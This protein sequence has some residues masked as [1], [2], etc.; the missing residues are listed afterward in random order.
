MSKAARDKT[1][2]TKHPERVKA[3]NKLWR[4]A[5]REHWVAQQKEARLRTRRAILALFGGKCAVCEIADPIVLDLDHIGGGGGADRRAGRDHT[6]LYRTVLADEKIQSN[7]RLLCRN[8]NWRE[9]IQRKEAT[10]HRS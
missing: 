10:C 8:C 1:Y 2:R 5:N 6:T 7:F 3:A 9:W 4:Q